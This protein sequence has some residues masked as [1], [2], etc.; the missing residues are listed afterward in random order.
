MDTEAVEIL[1]K[2]LYVQKRKKKAPGGSSKRAKVDAPSSV[3]PTA[4]AAAFEV[5]ASIEV[6]PTAEVSTVGAGFMPPAS[7][8]PSSKDQASE[9]PAEGEMEEGK[10]K[11]KAI[12]KTLHKARP[13]EPSDDRGELREDPF[14][15]LRIIQDL[16]DKFAMM[17]V[18]DR[19]ANLDPR[20]LI[21]GSLGTIL[22]VTPPLL[23]FFS[24]LLLFSSLLLFLTS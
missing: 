15:D 6:A 4:T 11:K 19:M 23:N 3:A 18:V 22:K 7:L 12:V 2:G 9:L 10:K 5:A 8:D 21:W 16:T 1:T 13:S 14:D 20:L 17:E 24:P